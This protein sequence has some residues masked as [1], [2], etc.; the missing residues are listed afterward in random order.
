M[1]TRIEELES[2]LNDLMQQ[3]GVQPPELAEF[4]KEER[5]IQQIEGGTD[6]KN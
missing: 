4:T 2:N 1:G 3:T 6:D 5:T